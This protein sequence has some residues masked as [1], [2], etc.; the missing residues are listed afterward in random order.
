MEKMFIQGG[1]ALLQKK[2][3]RALADGSRQLVITGN[4]EIEQTV[5]IPSDFTLILEN[6]HLRMADDTFC[7][8]FRNQKA[9]TEEGKTIE[10]AD[11]N[12]VI[13]GRGKAI[14]D[15]GN[16]NGLSESNSCKD[17]RPHISVNNL[18]LFHNVEHFKVS[19]LFLCNQRWWAMN[20][21]FCRF[22]H[23]HDIEFRADDRR[24]DKDGNIIHG[25]ICDEST[26]YDVIVRNADGLDLRHDNRVEI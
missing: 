18:I 6:C 26:W 12:I 2:I 8:M 13:E 19:G 20:F 9:G 14:L 25:H 5:L 11:R 17:G 4:F 23:I 15:G 10:G 16:Y 21:L 7:N 24:R 1:G 22:G 3:D